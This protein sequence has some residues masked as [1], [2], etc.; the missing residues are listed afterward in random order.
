[1]PDSAAKLITALEEDGYQVAQHGQG[2]RAGCPAHGG[3]KL[4]IDYLGFPNGG[5]LTVVSCRSGNDCTTEAILSTVGLTGADMYDPPDGPRAA[6]AGDAKSSVPPYEPPTAKRD[7]AAAG[8][9]PKLAATFEFTD[10]TGRYRY[11]VNRWEP[12][13]S[14]DH[15]AKRWTANGD[16]KSL[17]F[18][19]RLPGGKV[20]GSGIFDRAKYKDVPQH[21]LFNA[22]GVACAVADGEPVY[23]TEGMGGAERLMRDYEVT[24]TSLDGGAKSN[25]TP[26]IVG[27]LS[28]ATIVY[29]LMDDDEPGVGWV[30]NLIDKLFSVV[31][32][33]V[34]LKSATGM[35][36]DDVVDH[37]DAG[38]ELR[39]LV[40]VPLDAFR[41]TKEDWPDPPMPLDSPKLPPFPTHL[42]G[43]LAPMVRAVSAT[44]QCPE[45]YAALCGLG[46]IDTVLGGQVQVKL[47]ADWLEKHT[48][49][50]LMGFGDPSDGKSLAMD[51]MFK[52]VTSSVTQYAATVRS[53]LTDEAL[54][55]KLG[56]APAA[57]RAIVEDT[58]FESLI[59]QLGQHRG[60]MEL[61]SDEGGIFKMLGGMYAGSGK[62][63]NDA[64]MHKGYSGSSYTYDRV[65][66]NRKG[67]SVVI[68]L[69][70]LGMCVLAQPGILRGM[71]AANPNFKASGFLAR[72][73]FAIP[74]PLPDYVLDVPDIP[75]AVSERYARKIRTLFDRFWIA[76]LPYKFTGTSTTTNASLWEAVD[77]R[78]SIAEHQPE[79]LLVLGLPESVRLDFLRFNV[80]I[81]RRSKRDGDLFDVAYWAGKLPGMTARVAAALTLFENPKAEQLSEKAVRDAMSMTPFWL[82]HARAA[83]RLMSRTGTAN[84][85]AIRVREWART[86]TTPG[87][88][89]SLSD[90][91]QAMRFQTS[92][93]E[94]KADS[95]SAL[96]VLAEYG[97]GRWLNNNAEKKPGRP[98]S[99]KFLMHPLT[100]GNYDA[101]DAA[102]G[103]FSVSS[104]TWSEATYEEEPEEGVFSVSSGN[105]ALSAGH[106]DGPLG[107]AAATPRNHLETLKTAAA[108]EVTEVPAPRAARTPEQEAEARTARSARRAAQHEEEHRTRLDR[109]TPDELTEALAGGMIPAACWRCGAS[110]RHV[111]I[112]L[113]AGCI[114]AELTLRGEDY[115]SEPPA[116]ISVPVAEAAP[117][118]NPKK[119]RRK[120]A[121]RGVG[122]GRP[123]VLTA[124]QMTDIL[125]RLDAG[126]TQAALCREYGIGISTMSASVGRARRAAKT[127]KES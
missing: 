80:D 66:T 59:A 78:G 25:W 91:H 51:E 5:G 2:L 71:E 14:F 52:P 109:L 88:S 103:V 83:F 111:D 61:V 38:H 93:Y 67:E 32:E 100:Y 123:P 50:F 94:T 46:A 110:P 82:A 27:Q 105:Y 28:G 118:P 97:W 116:E 68:P 99:P 84:D 115:A 87:Q 49:K 60:R 117:A 89:F 54:Q 26:Y 6:G 1:M 114:R 11:H 85:P 48:G 22:V 4:D 95:E 112:S 8:G 73:L 55:E 29:A 17:H 127:Q 92:W 34:V 9:E 31:G 3:S 45:A 98:Q 101:D 39:A 108:K 43:A 90:V 21:T 75:E 20:I 65:G 124:D 7:K 76:A 120:G 33:I 72:I 79:E 47:K 126:E 81:R 107:V 113:C 19:R 63:S 86:H 62:G 53:F 40:E 15:E 30:R 18:Q 58:T 122:S 74:A 96:T 44:F 42:L 57:P 16:R 70:K 36:G 64:I 119:S 104:G 125:A 13:R 41:T 102:D 12:G 77:G 106:L 10:T 35:C 121:G 56:L 37:L 23:I 24:A 69:V